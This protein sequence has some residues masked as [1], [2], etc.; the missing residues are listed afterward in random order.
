[1]SRVQQEQWAQRLAL[2]QLLVQFFASR[3]SQ[4][5]GLALTS[6]S[7][8]YPCGTGAIKLANHHRAAALADRVAGYLHQMDM[9]EAAAAAAAAEVHMQD[10]SGEIS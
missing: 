10:A 4:R 9:A 3:N 1:M 8:T 6:C 7:P 5:R 2:Y